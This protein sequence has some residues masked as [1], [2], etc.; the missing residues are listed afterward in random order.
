VP[1]KSEL[2][3]SHYFN[4]LYKYLSGSRWE[5][6]AVLEK[7]RISFRKYSKTAKAD[8]KAGVVLKPLR[9]R[10]AAQAS[11]IRGAE[12]TRIGLQRCPGH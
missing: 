5:E 6:P 2:N 12:G 9:A 4:V 10:H 1:E 7:I 3:L 8:F 11:T